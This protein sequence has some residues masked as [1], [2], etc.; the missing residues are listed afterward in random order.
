MTSLEDASFRS[1]LTAQIERHWP[2]GTIARVERIKRGLVNQTFRVDGVR[3]D[4]VRADGV[5][6]QRFI[7]RLYN[8]E[9]TR[10]RIRKE[11][12]LL[13]W[14]ERVG[15]SLAPRLVAP[16]EPPSWKSLVPPHAGHRHMGL[17]T[18]LPGED[19]YTWDS[20][21][22]HPSAAKAL[23][24]VLSR[25][26][27]AIHRW[28]KGDPVAGEVDVLRRLA[29]HLKAEP[30]ALATL[31]AL[32]TALT[33]LDRR[34]WP[35]LVVHGDFHAA[36]VRWSGGRITGLFDFEY[37]DLNWRLY[38][39]ATAIACLAFGWDGAQAGRLQIALAQAFLDGY[40]GGP[41]QVAS[42]PCLLKEELAALPRYL[43]LAHL[44]TLEWTLMPGTRKRLGTSSADRY[45]QHARNALSWL[46]RNETL[47]FSPI[48]T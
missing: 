4:G 27:R 39:V 38:D 35:A 3:V 6:R 9:I 7:L 43:E 10:D 28:G 14:L 26:H 24:E 5:D 31:E 29:G 22:Q 16:L 21:P 2:T 23:G 12:D 48:E 17:M 15:F 19:R 44:L 46:G 1:R 37:A 36:N 47:P 34:N 40:R 30:A 20:P 18:Y 42:L 13:H 41:G 25:Y 8:P 45:A 11:H 32:Q 33:A